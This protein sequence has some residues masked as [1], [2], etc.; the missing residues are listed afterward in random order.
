VDRSAGRWCVYA[1]IPA[2]SVCGAARPLNGQRWMFSFSRYDYTRPS[3]HPIISSTSP[4]QLP[5]FHRQEEWGTLQFQAP[6]R[7]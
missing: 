3:P 4:H 2:A 7:K 5:G 6:E 1:E